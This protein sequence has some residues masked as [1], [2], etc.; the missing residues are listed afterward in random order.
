M[1]FLGLSCFLRVG[2]YLGL[3]TVWIEL[4]ELQGI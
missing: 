3:Q 4:V 1:A 2:W